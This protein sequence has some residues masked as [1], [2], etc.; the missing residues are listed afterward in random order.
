MQ[1]KRAFERQFRDD[2]SRIRKK[3]APKILSYIKKLDWKI[4]KDEDLE[5]LQNIRRNLN[6]YF[7]NHYRISS[8]FIFKYVRISKKHTIPIYGLATV[9]WRDVR[10]YRVMPSTYIILETEDKNKF[11]KSCKRFIELMENFDEVK[12]YFDDVYNRDNERCLPIPD[13]V[14]YEITNPEQQ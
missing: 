8:I 11:D 7:I 6:S 2:I 10:K 3:T 13:Y 9:Y 4:I 14:I 12:A 5:K 1:T